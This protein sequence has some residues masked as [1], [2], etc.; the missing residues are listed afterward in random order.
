MKTASV[1]KAALK[2][3]LNVSTK[4]N[5][6]IIESDLVDG[7]FIDQNGY[8]VALRTIAKSDLA[9]HKPEYDERRDSFHYSIKGFLSSFA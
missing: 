4:Y 6:V 2:A 3:G 9:D 5:L 8:A 7:G 1:I